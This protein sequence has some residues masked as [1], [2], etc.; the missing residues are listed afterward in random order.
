MTKSATV[1]VI[2][3]GIQ[4]RN[5]FLSDIRNRRLIRSGGEDGGFLCIKINHCEPTCAKT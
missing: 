4:T 2:F 5:V 1:T 3:V